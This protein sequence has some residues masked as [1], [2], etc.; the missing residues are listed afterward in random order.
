MT[1]KEL[2]EWAERNGWVER[3]SE[4]KNKEEEDGN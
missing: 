1:W 3:A 4:G 2:T